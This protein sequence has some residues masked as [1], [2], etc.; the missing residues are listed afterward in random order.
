MKKQ[1]CFANKKKRIRH[2]EFKCK[3]NINNSNWNPNSINCIQQACSECSAAPLY[4]SRD[5]R[6]FFL[7]I[8]VWSAREKQENHRANDQC[9]CHQK[10]H[11]PLADPHHERPKKVSVW[12]WLCFRVSGASGEEI[13]AAPRRQYQSRP[14][15]EALELIQEQLNK[16][17]LLTIGT[18]D[19]V[20][21]SNW[22]ENRRWKHTLLYVTC[23]NPSN[24]DWTDLCLFRT[25]EPIRVWNA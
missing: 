1:E 19:A 6:S 7:L 15:F 22:S 13:W 9:D 21:T 4:L 17:S 24:S 20:R 5:F 3:R 16:Y 18:F 11:P 23:H 25:G 8:R 14:E 2:A 10:L 12:R